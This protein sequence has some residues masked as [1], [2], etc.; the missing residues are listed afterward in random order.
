MADRD[1][2]LH[3]RVSSEEQ[4]MVQALADDAGLTASDVV[5]T[6]VR[7]AHRERFGETVPKKGGKAKK[8]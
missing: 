4:D 1:R 5:R 8:K 2:Q 6:L 3:L 7:K